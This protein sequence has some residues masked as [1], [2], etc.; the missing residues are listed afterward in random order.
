MS[1]AIFRVHVSF[2]LLISSKVFVPNS[3]LKGIIGMVVPQD[4]DPVGDHRMEPPLA[5]SLGRREKDDHRW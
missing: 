1:L 2:A 4:I 3:I 5:Q